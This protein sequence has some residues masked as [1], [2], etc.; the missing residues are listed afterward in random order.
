MYS[1]ASESCFT[2]KSVNGSHHHLSCPRCWPGLG[3]ASQSASLQPGPVS[4]Q[5]AQTSKAFP[6]PLPPPGTG[7]LLV[8][9]ILRTFII[10]GL[11]RECEF[12]HCFVGWKIVFVLSVMI[13]L[14]T[15]QRTPLYNH[16]VWL[17]WPGP[18]PGSRAPGGS[19][20]SPVTDPARRTE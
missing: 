7:R 13:F 10:P 5:S 9:P 16:R 14:M 4:A 20:R 2:A 1:R 11:C 8:W 18:G 6:R 17:G 12:C 15:V 19:P 3:P